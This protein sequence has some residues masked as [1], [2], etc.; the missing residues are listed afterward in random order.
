M[1]FVMSALNMKQFVIVDYGSCVKQGSAVGMV[2]VRGCTAQAA[3][4]VLNQE[5]LV[6]TASFVLGSE[7]GLLNWSQCQ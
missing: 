7:K 6:E 5:L 1:I 3:N 2:S 4:N